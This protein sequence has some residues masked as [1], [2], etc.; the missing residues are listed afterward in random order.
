LRREGLDF[1]GLRPLQLAV[2]SRP[3]TMPICCP[4]RDLAARI[5]RTAYFVALA[6]LVLATATT[7]RAQSVP[8][9]Q[10]TQI[11]D[12]SAL[13]PP[14][15][16]RVAIVEFED[17]QCP[18]CAYNN[19]LLK[20]AAAKYKIPWVRHDFLIPGHNWSRYAAIDARWFGLKSKAIGDE[21]RDQ[22]FLNQASI[23]NPSSLAQFTAK[24]AQSHGLVLPFAVDPQG[25]LAAQV[26]AD[27]ALG[28]RTGIKGTPAVFV[29]TANSK[30]PQ[31]IEVRDPQ[32]QLYTAIDQALADTAAAPKA[33]KAKRPAGQ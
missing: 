9:S 4:A 30:G 28:L 7:D 31:F 10:G 19:P 21:Y 13:H 17:Q 33:A 12:S 14:A 3:I 6:A 2:V 24:F 27:S 22:V 16:A 1:L 26:E 23:Y 15:G 20:T 5:S 25:T 8:P 18:S 32:M 11:L 29:V